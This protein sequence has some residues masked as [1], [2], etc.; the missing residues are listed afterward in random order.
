MDST[1]QQQPEENY[2][3]LQG[4]AAQKKSKT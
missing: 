3:D 1:N 2:E 4:D